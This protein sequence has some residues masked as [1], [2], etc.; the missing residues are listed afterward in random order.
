[1]PLGDKRIEVTFRVGDAG[2][3]VASV[4][5]A[6]RPV[7]LTPLHNPYRAAGV[8]VALEDLVGRDTGDGE[9][10]EVTVVTR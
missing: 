9:A 8:S 10:V 4:E 3:G 2:V 7:E 6:G 1:M 5:A